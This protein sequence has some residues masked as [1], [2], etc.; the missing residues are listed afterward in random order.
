MLY[1]EAGHWIGDYEANGQPIQQ[2]IWLDDL[3]V[4]LLVGA[5]A[6][7][8]LY[9]IEADALGTPRVVIDPDR[10]VAVWKWDLA[11]E[12]F[13]D[14]VPSED[15]DGDGNALVFDMRFPG[16]RYDAA[17]GLSYN[18]FRDYDPSTGR[19]AESDP[20][21][22]N[23]GIST[24]GYVAARPLI[25]MDFFGLAV[26]LNLLSPTQNERDEAMDNRAC[27]DTPCGYIYAEKYRNRANEFSVAAH[28]DNRG[29]WDERKGR[30]TRTS[31][32]AERLAKLISA[33]AEY[34]PTKVIRLLSCRSGKGGE[35]SLLHKIH[36]ILGNPV[37]GVN[38]RI[39]ADSSGLFTP[40]ADVNG[41]LQ[42][43]PSEPK[44]PWV[45]YP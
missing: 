38:D 24:Y 3:P 37:V 19:Y 35:E 1:D 28:G 12:A 44:S 17:S 25:S 23:G 13:G 42:K 33:H 14:A 29:I 5:G 41:N 27:G 22:L 36:E 26:T 31:L 7:Q 4:G 11:G 43:D 45:R 32:N 34:S 39:M 16:Q 2:A 30:D 8:K 40:Y 15:A 9:Y 20:I 18:Y 21:G 6:N 10:N